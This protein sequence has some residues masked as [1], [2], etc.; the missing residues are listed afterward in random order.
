MGVLNT[1]WRPQTR[2]PPPRNE[3]Q[4]STAPP[5]PSASP[6]TAYEVQRQLSSLKRYPDQLAEY[7]RAAGRQETGQEQGAPIQQCQKV[8]ESPSKSILYAL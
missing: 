5:V 8:S 1:S 6:K 3:V 4:R 7:V 2:R